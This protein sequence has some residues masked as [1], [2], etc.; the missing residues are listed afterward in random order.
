MLIKESVYKFVTDRIN[1][2]SINPDSSGSMISHSQKMREGLELYKKSFENFSEKNSMAVAINMFNSEY[3]CRPFKRIE[4]LDISYSTGGGTALY[5]AIKNGAQNLLD[6]IEEIIKVNKCIP[7]ATFVILSDGHSEGPD[8]SIREAMEAIQK[9]NEAGVNT[10][11][12]AFGSSIEA[13]F[14]EKLGFQS[15]KDIN[16]TETLVTFMG[17]ELSKSCKQ[18][19]KSRKSLGANF[20]SKAANKSHSAEYDAKTAQIL[21][22]DDWFA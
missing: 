11:F 8:I 19:S 18:Q 4:E 10:V 2:F 16:D 1:I 3:N 6:Y 15:T 7:I 20:F 21:E 9:L 17:E 5:Y 12:V 13:K 22:D 14:G